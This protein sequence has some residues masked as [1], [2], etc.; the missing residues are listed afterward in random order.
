[1]K[2]ETMNYRGYKIFVLLGLLQ[3]SGFVLSQELVM[4]EQQ[5]TLE[6]N[7]ADEVL[8]EAGDDSLVLD[9]GLLG[10]HWSRQ[11]F[12][13]KLVSKRDSLGRPIIEL[14]NIEPSLLPVLKNL[15]EKKARVSLEGDYAVTS[16]VYEG[17]KAQK[18]T[19][20]QV[21]QLL[22]ELD[23]M[24]VSQAI[25]AGTARVFVELLGDNEVDAE[26]FP[27][28]D[29]VRREINRYFHLMRDR[30]VESWP[31]G[32]V[33]LQDLLEFKKIN[34]KERVRDF[35]LDLSGLSLDYACPLAELAKYGL[36][37][38][39]L[40]VVDLGNNQ[41]TSVPGELVSNAQS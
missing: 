4:K 40:T 2:R 24:R 37:Y 19:V 21:G 17:L 33:W 3:L 6:D 39:S 11:L 32:E 18:L 14:S 9:K 28:N 29:S 1:M 25:I 30:Y 12:E 16:L 7:A 27:G 26:I 35:K 41:L 8:L 34:V 38:A 31:K 36:D 5:R 22:L 20:D 15:L 23:Y 13:Q 10:E